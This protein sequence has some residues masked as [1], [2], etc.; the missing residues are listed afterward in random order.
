MYLGFVLSVALHAGLLAWAFVN[1]QA[2][3]PFKTPQPEPV[4]VAII[5][6]DELVRLKKGNRRSKKL[7]AKKAKSQDKGKRKKARKQKPPQ[8]S[9]T[10]PPDPDAA[11]KEQLAKKKAE[12]KALALKRKKAA[13][14]KAKALALKR[15][16][17]AEAEARAKAAAKRRKALAEKKRKARERRRKKAAERRRK[18]LAEKR[19]KARLERQR[20][21]RRK[22]QLEDAVRQALLDKDPTKRRRRGGSQEEPDKPTKAK[23]PTAGAKEGKDQ[24]LTASEES[25]LIS[26]IRNQIRDCWRLPGG[27]GGVVGI[28]NVKLSWKLDRQG[29][30]IGEPRV[31]GRRGGTMYNLAAAA[32]VRAV[33]QCQPFNLPAKLYKHWKVI[34]EWVFDPDDM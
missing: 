18:R 24:R 22:K 11:R 4:E 21:A 8:P 16:K 20:R 27:G 6:P 32:A 13:E 31:L 12:A 28:P 7:Q 3:P 34:D 2:T 10:P 19:R 9:A 30:L 15:K 29:K 5:T 17:A 33:K 1:I 26:R 14:A 25:L 23:G